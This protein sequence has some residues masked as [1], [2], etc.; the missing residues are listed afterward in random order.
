MSSHSNFNKD[1]CWSC[2]YFSGKREYKK[3]MFLGDS[4]YTDV[5]GKCSN[6]RSTNCNHE[7]FEDGWCAKYQKWGILQSAISIEEQKKESQRILNEFHK[8]QQSNL[9]YESRNIDTAQEKLDREKEWKEYKHRLEVESKEKQIR[10]IQQSP[11]VTLVVGSIITLLAFLLGW[12]P[13]WY[14]DI[15]L[16]SDRNSLSQLLE[17]GHS[18][19]ETYLQEL[20]TDGLYSKDMRNSCIW[21]PFV[22]L[23]V[24]IAVTTILVILNNKSKPKRL[25][26]AQKELESLKK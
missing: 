11:I 4:V 5:K 13:Y 8:E 25:K 2:E 19:Q 3:G 23:A 14:W 24:G 22:I 9:S 1:K 15:R 26:V 10:K 21:I 18:M 6:N 20:Y 17:W 7:V 12:I 16:S